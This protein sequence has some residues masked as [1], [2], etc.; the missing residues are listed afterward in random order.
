M[1]SSSPPLR[2]PRRE[3]YSDYDD[4]EAAFIQRFNKYPYY[5]TID[6]VYNLFATMF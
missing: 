4:Y 1:Y 6:E 2:P 5:E 3:D